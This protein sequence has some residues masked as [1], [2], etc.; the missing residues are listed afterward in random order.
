[1]KVYLLFRNNEDAFLISK[2]LLVN[3]LIVSTVTLFLVF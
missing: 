2:N 1:M 3:S